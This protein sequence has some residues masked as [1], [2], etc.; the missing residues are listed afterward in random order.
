MKFEPVEY[1]LR[2]G[3]AAV[4]RSLGPDDADAA[5]A[6]G[7]AICAATDFLARDAGE[8]TITVEEEVKFLESR[9]SAER[10]AMI[11]AFIDSVLVGLTDFSP[12]SMT[13]KMR[14]RA[15][16]GISVLPE[17][18]NR[19]LGTLLLQT[20]IECAKNIGYEQLELE[21]VSNNHKAI[22]LYKKF[23]FITCGTIRHGFKHKNGSYSDLDTMV[24]NQKP[25]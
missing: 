11:G 8:W 21:V 15:H 9:L 23:S 3:S 1:V 10:A 19:G 17:F 20:L 7:A 22:H 25:I 18:E 6:Y 24:L 16:F 2:D 13:S 5:V 4:I 14:H 12:V